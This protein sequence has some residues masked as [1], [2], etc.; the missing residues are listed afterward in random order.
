M[1][2]DWGQDIDVPNQCTQVNPLRRS[3]SVDCG[4]FR[5]LQPMTVKHDT[6][7]TC[8]SPTSNGPPLSFIRSGLL[9]LACLL[10]GGFS[11]WL[12]GCGTEAVTLPPDYNEQRVKVVEIDL[13]SE[14]GSLSMLSGLQGGPTSVI[15][16]DNDLANPMR[17]VGT[18]LL[19]LPEGYLCEYSLAGTFP[20][21]TADTSNPDSYDFSLLEPVFGG[22]TSLEGIAFG[23]GEVVFQATYDIGLNTCSVEGGLQQGARPIDPQRWAEVVTNV[24]RYLNRDLLDPTDGI[25]SAWLTVAQ[26]FQ[27]RWVESHDDPLGRGGYDDVADVVSDFVLL[28]S[29]IRDVFSTGAG[30]NVVGPSMVFRDGDDVN[31]HPMLEFVDAL[32]ENN[33]TDLIDAVSFQLD[34]ETPSEAFRIASTLRNALNA[35]GLTE[36]PLWLTKYSL[37]ERRFAAPKPGDNAASWSTF[38]GA[39]SNGIRIVLQGVVEQAVYYRGDR[40][41]VPDGA[42]PAGPQS[43]LWTAN[44]V[45]RPMWY[46]WYPWTVFR[47]AGPRVAA[48][49]IDGGAVDGLRVMAIRQNDITCPPNSSGFAGAG[50]LAVHVMVANSDDQAVV[51]DVQYQLRLKGVDTDATNVKVGHW[52]VDEARTGPPQTPPVFSEEEVIPVS[53]DGVIYQVSG[54]VPGVSYVEFVFFTP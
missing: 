27:V 39:W 4:H 13:A 53:K 6:V 7:N 10:L 41:R 45:A 24:M 54:T 50:C 42:D 1:G 18:Q 8:K 36:T 33:Q 21:P 9:K 51:R 17:E 46:A 44:G 16:G 15:A 2:R 3:Q 47:A 12:H 11:T 31:A 38:S 32:V 25:D 40:A 5:A 30:V 28:A 29:R 14:L 34:V 20:N 43:P 19:R 23:A 22:A 49:V 26:D 48:E 37:P 35:R 52:R